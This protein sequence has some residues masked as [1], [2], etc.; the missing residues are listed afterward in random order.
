M[1]E[2]II[3]EC[4]DKTMNDTNMW[5]NSK[6]EYIKKSST[7]SKGTFGELLAVGIAKSIGI[8]A[9]K[10]EHKGSFDVLFNDKKIEVK[11]ATLDTNNNFQFNGIRKLRE[12]DY[13][14]FIGV[15]PN[16]IVYNIESKDSC[17]NSTK[18]H[19]IPMEKGQNINSHGSLK[20]TMPC[21]NML[22]D[23]E[24]IDKLRTIFNV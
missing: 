18:Y 14:F 5:S 10:N 7:T 9:R 2:N 4:K 19:L 8:D 12:Y 17:C 21:L 20:L 6:Y 11:L 24:I 22:K 3:N 1:F 13:V 16:D 15:T 23:T